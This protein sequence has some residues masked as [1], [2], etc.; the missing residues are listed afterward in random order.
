MPL[1]F[2]SCLQWAA[3][4]DGVKD[5]CIR[6]FSLV[7]CSACMAAWCDA[8]GVVALGASILLLLPPLQPAV[9]C[10]QLWLRGCCCCRH[11]ASN[12][13]LKSTGGVPWSV[14]WW[15]VAVGLQTRA[16]SPQKGAGLTRQPSICCNATA[17]KPL[18]PKASFA[19]PTSHRVLLK[20][21]KVSDTRGTRGHPK[22]L[23]ILHAAPV[24][25]LLRSPE[26]RKTSHRSRTVLPVLTLSRPRCVGGA[27]VFELLGPAH[28]LETRHR[29]AREG[30]R[31][32]ASRGGRPD[33][34]L[35]LHGCS[36]GSFRH[37]G[38]KR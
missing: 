34:V 8:P 37:R 7:S 24:V 12:G 18:H 21:L 10:P 13:V 11:N 1:L 35:S 36:H 4:S 16:L 3:T 23:A 25:Q 5:A 14:L 29:L 19:P 2:F 22:T 6:T 15:W 31:D 9:C 26:P 20:L 28:G 30:E 32:A 38:T 27:F 17:S 33:W